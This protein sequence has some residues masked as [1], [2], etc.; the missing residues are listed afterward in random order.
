MKELSLKQKAFCDYYLETM[1]ATEAYMKAYEVDYESANSAAAK[2]LQKE[3]IKEYIAN[4]LKQIDNKN[5]ATIEEIMIF[6]TRV[7]RGD[8][9][10]PIRERLKAAELLGK[11][12]S[13][14]TEKVEVNG[15]M[16]LNVNIKV[17][18]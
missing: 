13:M 2:L 3:E 17:V 4:R 12:Y 5:I 10:A 14:F 11:R 1:N 6:L 15:D 9:R 18:E 16:E 8:I 7:M